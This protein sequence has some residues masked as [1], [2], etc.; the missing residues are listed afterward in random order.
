MTFELLSDCSV[1]S[2]CL[3]GHEDARIATIYVNV[4]G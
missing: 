3:F 1:S 2:L 4:D